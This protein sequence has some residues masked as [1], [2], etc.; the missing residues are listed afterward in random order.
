MQAH[1]SFFKLSFSRVKLIFGV[2]S[3]ILR[4]KTSKNFCKKHTKNF[5]IVLTFFSFL[6]L[7]FCKKFFQL[8]YLTMTVAFALFL[9][10]IQVFFITPHRKKT[11]L[12]KKKLLIFKTMV[13]TFC[14]TC[15]VAG[16]PC[17]FC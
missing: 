4:I 3:A 8:A 11:T 15:S 2:F 14:A 1:N 7:F 10:F 13:G 5:K 17:F 6:L 9:F 12:F 16:Y